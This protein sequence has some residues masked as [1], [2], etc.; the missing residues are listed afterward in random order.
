MTM[1]TMTL[2]PLILA[3]PRGSTISGVGLHLPLSQHRFCITVDKA[4]FLLRAPTVNQQQLGAAIL[5]DSMPGGAHVGHVPSC[6][7]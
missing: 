4:P 2:A 3:T 7:L 6:I 5:L 1:M